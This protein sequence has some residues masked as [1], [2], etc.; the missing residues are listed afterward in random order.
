MKN[1]NSIIFVLL[2]CVFL[3]TGVE[4][5]FGCSPVYRTPQESF[6]S[7]DLVF[8]GRVTSIA[9]STQV[10]VYDRTSVPTKISTMG[11]KVEKYWKG[12]P[13]EYVMVKS[14]A[15]DGY[16][17]PIFVPKS[18]GNEYL[19]YANKD[20]GSNAYFVN[21]TEIKEIAAA[22]SEIT[23]LGNGFTVSTAVKTETDTVQPISKPIESIQTVPIVKASPVVVPTPDSQS[24]A[25]EV[26]VDTDVE[27]KQNFIQR[28]LSWFGSLFR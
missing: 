19:V 1:R 6:G 11:F 17:C 12:N 9:T 3:L 24:K 21:Y 16:S 10:I 15:P 14:T 5:T 18:I 13:T 7:A 4:T 25:N 26:Q 8:S 23:L 2:L 22:N 27:V 20:P 28:I